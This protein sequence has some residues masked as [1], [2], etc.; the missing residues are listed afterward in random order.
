MSALTPAGA[1]ERLRPSDAATRP[2]RVR[3]DEAEVSLPPRFA[4]L[5]LLAV[6][7]IVV[8][9]TILRDISFRGA[10][11]SLLTVLLVWTGLR[12]GVS[13]G[14]W[15]G[16]LAGLI[17][18]A[19]GGGGVNVIGTTLIGFAAGLL[20][21]RFF[22]DSIPVFV[23]AVAAATLVRGAVS[24]LIVNIGLGERGMFHRLSHEIV[25]QMALNCVLAVAALLTLR[26]VQ[27]VR[28]R[29]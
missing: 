8:Q 11:P 12:C 23:A 2:P 9:S 18:D 5:L 1:L 4:W 19:L 28:S 24:Y 29:A 21:V 10:H 14:G 26:V 7:A 17:E 16:F 15:L 27:H 6:V 25:W 3:L 20:N 13:T 22:A